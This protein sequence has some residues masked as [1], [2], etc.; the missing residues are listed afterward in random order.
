[1]RR[2]LI[3]GCLLVSTGCATP[4]LGMTRTDFLNLTGIPV[5]IDRV[6]PND[7]VYRDADGLFYYFVNEQLVRIERGVPNQARY[8][9]E[10]INR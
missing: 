9:Y 6:A 4:Y 10:I 2:I 7:V 5:T 8:Q 1:M 3:V